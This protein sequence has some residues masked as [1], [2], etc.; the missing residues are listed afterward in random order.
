MQESK[1]LVKPYE[2]TFF[3][4]V[5]TKFTKYTRVSILYQIYRFIVLNIKILRMVR[6]H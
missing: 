6:K 1:E 3:T 5:P 4:A 2:Q